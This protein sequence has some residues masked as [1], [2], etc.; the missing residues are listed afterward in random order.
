MNLKESFRYQNFLNKLM[1]SG[2]LSIQSSN[3]GA[4][5]TKRHLKKKANPDAEDV[6][7][8]VENGDF[9]PNDD[10]IA[11]MQW[12]INE[13]EKLTIAIGKAK[14]SIGF[15]IDA[16]VE[17]NK[18]RQVLSSGI[19]DMLRFT[20][21]KR[22]EQ[23]C[24]YKFNVAGDQTPYR[25]E[26]EVETQ[27]AFDR[28]NAKKIM[29]EVISKADTVSSEI[30]MA[31]INTTVDYKPPFNVNESFEDIMAEFITKKPD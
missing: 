21:S 6:E 31:M 13:R 15:D 28:D 17:T 16:A 9:Y 14:A 30:D 29:R 7:E 5:V 3:H 12:L 10:V 11:F 26:I 27:D 24:D 25:Y 4:T 2:S 18:F 22:I 20:P 8:K 1:L 23:G 19:K